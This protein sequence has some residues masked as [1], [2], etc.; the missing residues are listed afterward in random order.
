MNILIGTVLIW[1][2]AFWALSYLRRT[3]PEAMDDLRPKAM[4]TFLYMVPRIFVGVAGAG[5]LAA[6]LPAGFVRDWLGA[7][8]GLTGIALSAVFGALTPGGPFIAFAIGASALKAGAGI[9]A[10]IAYVTAWSMFALLRTLS[11]ELSLMGAPFVGLRFAV[12]A[13]VPLLLGILAGWL[14]GG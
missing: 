9:G 6:L 4:N 10:L 11:Y 3:A 8:S 14:A 13:P 1:A 12:S 7:G 5:F 2:G